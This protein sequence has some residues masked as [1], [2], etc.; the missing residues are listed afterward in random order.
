MPHVT[1][2]LLVR[3]CVCVCVCGCSEIVR[4]LGKGSARLS[5][6]QRNLITQFNREWIDCLE[7]VCTIA[8]QAK[9]LNDFIDRVCPALLPLPFFFGSLT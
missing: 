5:S 2:H 1:H 9:F 7:P 6:L 3:G 4:F 8:E